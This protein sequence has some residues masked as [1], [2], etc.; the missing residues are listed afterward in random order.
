MN[1]MIGIFEFKEPPYAK[2]L[3]HEALKKRQDVLIKRTLP[4]DTLTIDRVGKDRHR[5]V[6]TGETVDDFNAFIAGYATKF[7]QTPIHTDTGNG[8]ELEGLVIPG[9]TTIEG[10]GTLELIAQEVLP[11]IVEPIQQASPQIGSLVLA[12]MFIYA[13]IRR[14]DRT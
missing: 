2:A 11:Q 7:F 9:E 5:F 3:G 1:K 10:A 6:V 4:S 14:V 12:G 13:I 8:M